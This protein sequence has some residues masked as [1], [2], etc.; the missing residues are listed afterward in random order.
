LPGERAL[1]RKHEQLRRGVA[2]HPSI[3][4][5]LARWAQRFGMPAPRPVA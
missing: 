1:A 5:A 3:L 2:L 4:P